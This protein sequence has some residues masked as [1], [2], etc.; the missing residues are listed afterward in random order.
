MSWLVSS[1]R[2]AL[3]VVA[4]FV[5]ALPAWQ[6]LTPEAEPPRVASRII[7]E[8]YEPSSRVRPAYEAAA[9]GPAGDPLLMAGQRSAPTNALTMLRPHVDE[10]GI[11]AGDVAH[12]GPGSFRVATG[13]D[14]APNPDLRVRTILVRAEDGLPIDVDA[15]A[16]VVMDV[17]NDSRGW[18]DVLGVSFARTDQASEA[19]LVL[20]IATPVTTDVLCH[21]VLTN[22]RVSCGRA[23]T[24]TINANNYLSASTPFLEAGGSVEE[25]RRYVINHEVGHFLGQPH[26]SCPAPGRTAPVMLQQTLRLQGCVPNGWPNP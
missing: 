26:V 23:T 18:R 17:L 6:T 11:L 25:Y 16:G 2:A 20:T 5:L 15:F 21:P 10:W 24:V 13:S 22:S 9:L 7:A 3:I 14:P 19:N 1:A 8:V 4:A 12:S